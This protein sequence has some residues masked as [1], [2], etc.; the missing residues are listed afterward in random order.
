[1]RKLL[2]IIGLLCTLSVA[3]QFASPAKFTVKENKI[4][5]SEVEII[6]TGKVD[7]GWHVYSVDIPS[8]G[9]TAAELTL[10][11]QTGVKPKGKLQ[12][13][14][15]VQRHMDDMFGME[16]SY[17]EGTAIFVQ[18]FTI[19][20]EKYEVAGYLTYGACNDQNCVSPT[21]VDFSFA[22]TG[23]PA[24]A[25]AEADKAKADK[26][27]TDK[28]KAA[29][30]AKAAEDEAKAAQEQAAAE[31]AAAATADSLA[32]AMEQA[33]ADSA[34]AAAAAAPVTDQGIYAPV[35]DE[36]KSMGETSTSG[37]SLWTIFLMGLAGGLV[38]LVTP[39][40][41]PIIPMTVSFFLKSPSATQSAV[42]ALLRTDI[43]TRKE[44]SYSLSDPLL[45][46]W[47]RRNR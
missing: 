3:A 7:A 37:L 34:A 19:T 22:G 41:W 32:A 8:G 1:M 27:L 42:K 30:D 23:K 31:T 12:A 28:E 15:K 20:A 39:C 13:R 44:G 33:K 18:V 4:S 46:L 16:L 10:E 29:A 17:M 45:D 38:A 47:L 26:A 36:L 35:A 43:I 14:G 11:K 40:V 6:F 21:N 9:P 24:A 5:D 2:S 25:A